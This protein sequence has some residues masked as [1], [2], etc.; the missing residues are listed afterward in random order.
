MPTENDFGDRLESKTEAY[1]DRL[2]DCVRLLPAVFDQYQAGADY[3][4]TVDEIQS[5]ESELDEMNRRIVAM[6]TSAGPADMG[7]L[8]TRI[9]FNESALIEFY[10]TV[11]VVANL[12]ERIAQEIVMMQPPHDTECFAGLLDLADEIVGMTSALDEVV[13]RFVRSLSTAGATDTLT[14]EIQSI[15]DAESRCDELRNDVI[16]TAFRDDDVA[17]P[18]VYREFAILL[19]D[20]ANKMEDITDQIVVIA[21]KEPGI[22]TETDPDLE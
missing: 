15:R 10:N 7:L 4:E 16:A 20:V 17:D 9:N 18:L 22:V 11:D 3:Q 2:N 13:R 1:L 14:E 8:N 6:I 5:I 21:S 12:T 19:D